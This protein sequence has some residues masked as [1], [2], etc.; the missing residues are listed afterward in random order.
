MSVLSKPSVYFPE[1]TVTQ[2]E[3]I[4]CLRQ[5]HSDQ[6]HAEKAFDMVRNSSIDKRHLIVPLDKVVSLEGFDE[7]SVIY[8]EQARLMS[9][10]TAR[11]AIEN[12]GLQPKDISMVIVTSCTGFMMPSLTAHLINALNLKDSTIQLPMAQMG[13]VAGAAAVNRAFDHCNQSVQ[14]NA[15]I[16]ALETS[17]LC[18]D[19][20]ANRIQDFV[21]NS[22][23]GDAC[24]AV[25]MRGDDQTG[26]MKLTHSA[27]HFLPESEAFIRYD[28]TP[29][30]FKFSLDKEVMYSIERV[31]PVIDQFVQLSKEKASKEL[32][33]Y[34]F[35]TGGRRIQ[36]EV[37]RTLELTSDA[38]DHSR[39]CL[40]ET[41]NTSSAAVIDVL[42]RSFAHRKAGEQGVMAAFGPGFTT[43]MALGTWQ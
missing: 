1:Y 31:A 38:L 20:Y 8:D 25:V 19:K 23:F 26:G 14:N 37:E 39:A 40:R 24:A 35:H 27:C 4:E 42:R 18:F 11:Q 7:R 33:F 3:I 13:C 17:S 41:G 22:L 43:E 16:V 15:L 36:D 10:Q 2:E 12:A 30:G 9:E 28:M 29:R 6:P 5:L 21:T 34:L 32:D